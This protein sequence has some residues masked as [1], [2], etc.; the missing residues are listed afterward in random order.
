M[1]VD[2]LQIGFQKCGTTFLATDVYPCNPHLECIQPAGQYW[3]LEKLL[4]RDFILAD[5]FEYDRQGFERKFADI[6]ETVFI[7]KQAHVRGII[8][9]PFTFLYQRRFDRKN[10]IDRINESFPGVKIIMFVRSQQTWIA[11]HYSQYLKAG[12][13]LGWHDFVESILSNENLDAH[14]IDWFPLVSYLYKLFGP[15]RVLIC[16]FEELRKA[17]QDI[18]NRVFD[19]VGVPRTQIDESPANPSLSREVMPLKRFFNHLVHFDCGASAYNL[20]FSRPLGEARPS[21]ISTWYNIFSSIWYK[22]STEKICTI[23]DRIF[24]FK[25]R[26]ELEER[27]LEM[28]EQKYSSNNRKL[29]KLLNVDLSSYGYPYVKEKVR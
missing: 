12:G 18:A 23:I 28:I 29:S 8:F 4:L 5:G 26:L 14:Y 13:L 6:C 10:V 25:G 7:N 17:P 27:H 22:T 3:E 11:S 1:K 19:F 16:L 20:N 15:E 9:E 2:F 21:K 24:G